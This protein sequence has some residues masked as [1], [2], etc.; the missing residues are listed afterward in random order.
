[1]LLNL[2]GGRGR[3]AAPRCLDEVSVVICQ[4]ERGAALPCDVL[5]ILQGRTQAEQEADHAPTEPQRLGGAAGKLPL[6]TLVEV[7]E[8][9]WNDL[10][11][12]R[13][14]CFEVRGELL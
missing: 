9:F 4:L 1:M 10:G 13:R 3:L 2:G 11:P 12:E 5:E 6:Q 14:R 8:A 7:Q